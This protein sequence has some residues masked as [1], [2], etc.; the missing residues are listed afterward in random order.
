MTEDQTLNAFAALSHKTRL[1]V[2]RTLV[3]AAPNG[4]PAGEIATAV[5]AS[6]SRASF[7]LANLSDAGL[8]NAE[9]QAKTIYYRVDFKALGL[10]ASFLLHDCCAGSSGSSRGC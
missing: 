6:P 4:M 7:H 5:G 9:R 3:A 1:R 10:I 2:I 8:V